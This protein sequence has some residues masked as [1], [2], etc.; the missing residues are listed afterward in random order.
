M[1]VRSAMRSMRFIVPRNRTLVR[2]NESFIESAS[3]EEERISS[4]M[5]IVI[6][7]A[8]VSTAVYI[9]EEKSIRL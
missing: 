5:A 3:E 8:S 6:Y 4:P 2:S 7:P 1:P 9:S